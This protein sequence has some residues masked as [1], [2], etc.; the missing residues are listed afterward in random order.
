M[1]SILFSTAYLPPVEYFVRLIK[2]KHI[3]IEKQESFTKQTYR[4]RCVIA[5]P[6]GLQT[7]SIPV[8]HS[9]HDSRKICDIKIDYSA[10]WQVNQWRSIEAAYN[11]S[12]FFTFYRDEFEPFYFSRTKYLFDLNQELLALCLKLTQIK[13][14]INLTDEFQKEYQNKVDYRFAIS[15][16]NHV[17]AL[18][19][20][21]YPQVFEPISGFA[22]NLSFI[23]LL[24]NRGPDAS[25][26]L[27]SVTDL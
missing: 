9:N 8:I 16:K 19:F 13:T 26:Y 20:P 4:N 14:E 6:N 23:D 17:P 24:F 1:E 2:A 18:N 11:K 21:R 10:R 25:S 27:E 15:P 22:P 7:L 12:P 5:G 3:C